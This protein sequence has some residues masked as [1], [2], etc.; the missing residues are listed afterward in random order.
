MIK[1]MI[2]VGA[3]GPAAGARAAADGSGRGRYAAWLPPGWDEP[4]PV[5]RAMRLM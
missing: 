2:T 1:N 3:G 5:E 4:G